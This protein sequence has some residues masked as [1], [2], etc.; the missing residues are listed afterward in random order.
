M[1][2]QHEA[3]AMVDM[4]SSVIH[5]LQPTPVTKVDMACSIVQDLQEPL[6]LKLDAYTETAEVAKAPTP[7]ELTQNN[8]IVAIDII[9]ADGK[10]QPSELKNV[11]KSNTN[12]NSTEQD[13]AIID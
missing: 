8:N 6:V 13:I 5:E 2:V 3:P 9:Q 7:A 11:S 12:N 10:Q 4:A 1:A